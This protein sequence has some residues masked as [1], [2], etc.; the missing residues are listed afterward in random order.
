MEPKTIAH[1]GV[2]TDHPELSFAWN[3]DSSVQKQLDDVIHILANEYMW[4]V[5]ENPI[6]FSYEKQ[7]SCGLPID[8]TP[9]LFSEQGGTK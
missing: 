3:R 2:K 6:L 8:M 5:K 7:D 1:L 9:T 4:A